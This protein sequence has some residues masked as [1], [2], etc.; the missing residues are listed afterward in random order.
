MFDLS[1]FVME[2]ID[3]M[4]GKEPEHKVR[5]YALGWFEKNVLTEDDLAFVDTRYAE[6]VED[7]TDVGGSAEQ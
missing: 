4:I 7:D 6:L 2:T 5:Q 1:V 3:A